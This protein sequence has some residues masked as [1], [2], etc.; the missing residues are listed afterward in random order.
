MNE[1]AIQLDFMECNEMRSEEEQ[2]RR[3]KKQKNTEQKE[4]RK[5]EMQKRKK[6]VCERRNEQKVIKKEIKEK[7]D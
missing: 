1:N 7:E 6:D 3:D 5:R 4:T 2:G